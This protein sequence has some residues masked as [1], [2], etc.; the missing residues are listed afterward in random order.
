MT[1]SA[2]PPYHLQVRAWRG[3]TLLDLHEVS[4]PHNA[5]I[6]IGAHQANTIQM[7]L[8]SAEQE[9]R[10][11]PP[12]SLLAPQT[13]EWT[14][15]F[16]IP[17]KVQHKRASANSTESQE[18]PKSIQRMGQ[19]GHLWPLQPG[20]TIEA[21]QG[22]W[23]ITCELVEATVAPSIPRHWPREYLLFRLMTISAIS[24]LALIL[25]FRM[26]PAPLPQEQKQLPPIELDPV[27]LPAR[28]HRPRFAAK[29]FAVKPPARKPQAP[30]LVRLVRRVRPVTKTTK[31]PSPPLRPHTDFPQAPSHSSVQLRQRPQS[32]SPQADPLLND[33]RAKA[34]A[35]KPHVSQRPG[36]PVSRVKGAQKQRPT[37]G[38]SVRFWD[39]KS[40]LYPPTYARRQLALPSWQRS[41]GQKARDK[42]LIRALLKAPKVRHQKQAPNPLQKALRK[43]APKPQ[44][45]PKDATSGPRCYRYYKPKSPG[46]WGHVQGH[47]VLQKQGQGQKGEAH[48]YFQLCL[49]EKPR[50]R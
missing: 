19:R 23:R 6:T 12:F 22:Q 7:P 1:T 43:H 3:N 40:Y 30:R 29:S 46:V 36:A 11:L 5:S 39:H 48:P 50:R 16:P 49:R 32:A 41:Q 4:D 37:Q 2:T 35:K 28:Q 9:P 42:A 31:A 38:L 26:W 34:K 25:M 44:Q 14:L 18:P 45:A 24:H 33:R 27:P 15:F 13:Q 20:D 47:W 17:L 21:Q 8:T 10:M